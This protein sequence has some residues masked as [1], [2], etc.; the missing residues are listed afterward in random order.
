MSGLA[1]SRRRQ[2]VGSRLAGV[3]SLSGVRGTGTGDLP[4]ELGIGMGV[5]NGVP[6]PVIGT[7]EVISNHFGRWARVIP[8][9]DKKENIA[10]S[11]SKATG[12]RAYHKMMFSPY[13]LLG[14]AQSRIMAS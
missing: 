5:V 7:A 11:I 6:L 13:S 3:L 2:R 8:G 10:N 4:L 12:N 9:R 1:R 14:I